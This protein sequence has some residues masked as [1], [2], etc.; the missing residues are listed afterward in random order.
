M[1]PRY[2][3]SIFITRKI[4][5]NMNIPN[6][7]VKVYCM[8]FNHSNY[9]T[10]AMEGFC[11][12][13]TQF[14]FVCVIIDDAS[15][16]GEQEVIRKYIEENFDLTEGE[17][18]VSKETEDTFAT[19]ARHKTNKNCYFAVYY[20]KE[21]HYSKRRPKTAYMEEYGKDCKYIAQCE[22]D[23]YWID[24]LKLQKQVDFLEENEDTSM[25]CARTKLFSEKKQEYIGENRCL[26]HS[27]YLN[28]N[29]VI[30]KGDNIG[31]LVPPVAVFWYR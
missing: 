20:L 14:P 15:T 7:P 10:D 31:D 1:R 12:Q 21:N 3:L 28:K 19:F 29:D 5:E 25:V 9:I 4:I 8:T 23:D 11:M 13:R 17:A 16:D 18:V 6:F 22:G 24:P 26:G 2:T 27:G 30:L